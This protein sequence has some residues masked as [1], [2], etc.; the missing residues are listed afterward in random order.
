MA[1]RTR[2]LTTSDSSAKAEELAQAAFELFCSRGIDRVNLDE[3]AAAAG[4]TKGSLYWHYASKKAVVLAACD[5]YYARW[6]EQI[7]AATGGAESAY[8]KLE[9]AIAYSVRSCLL[10]EANRVFS[11]E[12][13]AL[14]LYDTEVRASWAGFLDETE[15]FFLGLTHQAVGRGELV[16]DD[17]DRAV[18]LMLAAMEGIKQTALFRPQIC[19]PQSEQRTERRLL[20]L[21]GD[22]P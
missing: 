15:R 21:L 2:T 13:V 8:G 11:T 20:S 14:S 4:V 10:D 22:R 16:C 7:T 5:V 18:D 12:I 17:V 6:R 1:T 3:I 9:V 19:G